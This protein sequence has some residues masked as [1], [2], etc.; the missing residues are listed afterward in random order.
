MFLQCVYR[1]K[2]FGQVKW[3]LHFMGLGICVNVN[4]SVFFSKQIMVQFIKYSL[5]KRKLKYV[6]VLH[7]SLTVISNFAFPI[8]QVKLS[9]PMFPLSWCLETFWSLQSA[10]SSARENF[11]GQWQFVSPLFRACDWPLTRRKSIAAF[12]QSFG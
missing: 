10:L 4:N 5:N 2:N 7:H 8:N 11:S 12:C 9:G 1:T 3:Q 6:K